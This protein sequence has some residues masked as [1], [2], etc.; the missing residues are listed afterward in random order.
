MKKHFFAVLAMVI[1]CHS[2]LAQA[3]DKAKLDAYF[4]AL[5]QNDKFMGSVALAKDGSI[6]YSRSVGYADFDKKIKADENSKYRIGSITKT[7]TAVLV[8]KGV[9]AN[10]INLD[11]SI[12]K[13]FPKIK[14]AKRITIAHLL[15]H[16]S[17]IAS[18]TSN[19]D[20]LTWN[21]QPKTEKELMKII[22]D[23][24][25]VFE[26][27]SRAEYSNSNY[28]LLTFILE[29][30][31]KKSYAELLKEHITEPLGLKNTMMG[32]KIEPGKN[33][34][35]SYK[36]IDTWKEESETDISIPLGAGGIVSTAGDLTKFAD[37]LLNGKLLKQESLEKMKTIKDRYGMGLVQFPFN[38]K[39]AYG[40]T[41]G[42]DGFS[43]IF[44][45]FP[46]DNISYALVSNG[47]NYNN[48]NI[49]L[50]VLSAAFNVPYTIPEFKTIA[51]S[52]EELDKYLGVYASEQMPLKITIT[53]AEKSLIAQ[54]TG[55]PAFP[56]E[57]TEKDIF[58]FEQ[59]GV[60]MEF[61]TVNHT[62]VLKQGGGVYNFKKE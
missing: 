32:S 21:T 23:G 3:F 18:F 37:A 25:S 35:K 33:E 8:F 61:N 36:F 62:F 15:S 27:D 47:S 59:A 57:A 38:D 5:E 4:D 44:S 58:K 48:N 20:Y 13:Y 55:Q 49:S 41:G 54:A 43:S 2:V 52:A 53:K 17:G 46:G 16:R 1:M 11:Q 45:N 7:F 51:L 6:I 9:E 42:I 34:C 22:T 30:S 56:L 10:L 14:N 40:H 19:P 50:A 39:K 12:D 29:K 26:P 24:G 28:V 60:V 31:F